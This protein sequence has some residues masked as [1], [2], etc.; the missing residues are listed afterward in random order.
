MEEIFFVTLLTISRRNFSASGREEQSEASNGR[1]LVEEAWKSFLK[2]FHLEN[3]V[4]AFSSFR[5]MNEKY[6]NKGENMRVSTEYSN[7]AET[8]FSFFLECFS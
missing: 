3:K 2:V 5:A 8:Y 7:S 4:S 6:L 1:R